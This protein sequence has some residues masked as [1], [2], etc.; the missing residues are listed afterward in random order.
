VISAALDIGMRAAYSFKHP[1]KSDSMATAW[2]SVAGFV[3]PHGFS[4]YFFSG[5]SCPIELIF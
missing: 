3:C 4:K 5:I 1:L 2:L